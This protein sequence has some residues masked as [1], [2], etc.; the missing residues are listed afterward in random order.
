MM[1][2]YCSKL[3]IGSVQFGLDYGISN[4]AG[5]TSCDEVVR[6][7]EYAKNNNISFI[8]TAFL[9]GDSE[10]VLGQTNALNNFTIVTKTPKFSDVGSKFEL[11]E[12]SFLSSIKK[13]KKVPDYLLFHDQR[14][15]LSDYSPSLFE[16][17]NSFK[18]KYGLKK[19][20]VSVY[21]PLSASLI[22]E[23]FNVDVIQLPYNLYDQRFMRSG[24]VNTFKS[25]GIEVHTRSS[26]LQGVLLME[27]LPKQLSYFEKEHEKFISFCRNNS[28]TQLQVA[29]KFVLENPFIDKVVLGFNDVSQIRESI[30]VLAE[31]FD[32]DFLVELLSLN[33]DDEFLIDPSKW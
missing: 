8:D 33:V 24:L 32:S 21:D 30:N 9:Y 29:L 15:L 7:L 31:P 10:K 26:F 19:I 18:S 16:V 17:A 3:A 27:T 1:K 28:L 6:I 25:K 13:L 22:I 5:K 2:N 12:S 11:L 4:S 14:D 23:R 20:G